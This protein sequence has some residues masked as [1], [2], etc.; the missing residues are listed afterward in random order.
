[1]NS[2]TM[3]LSM[4]ETALL[5]ASIKKFLQMDDIKPSDRRIAEQL[6]C[7]LDLTHYGLRLRLRIEETK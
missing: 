2:N 5:Q 7:K 4:V 3:E 1:M 6:E